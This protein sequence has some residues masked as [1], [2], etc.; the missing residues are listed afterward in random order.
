VSG[1]F[2]RGGRIVWENKKRALILI[3]VIALSV[4]G[5]SLRWPAQ[6]E[7]L[8]P[9]RYVR[10][11]G[12]IEN[13]DV[14]G[15]RRTLLPTVSTGYFSLPMRE[16][17]RVARSYPWVDGVQVAR[18]WPDTLVVRISEQKARVRWGDHS[19]LNQ[20][21]ERF[22]PGGL[23]AFRELPAIV[24]PEGMENY[25][26]GMLNGL[27]DRLKPKG[28]HIASLDMSKRR[29][30]VV[31]LTN[32]TEVHFGRQDP[33]KALNRFLELMPKLGE[34]RI[35][36]VQR[37]DLRYPNGFAVVW[38]PDASNLDHPSGQDGRGEFILS[39]K[40]VT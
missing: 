10:V 25:L 17:E 24:G 33:M 20:R 34:D 13:L 1:V 30:W 36:A 11:E 3:V 5:F 38:K 2:G 19:L 32:G 8:F 28:L 29:A 6:A 31:R 9:I 35:A 23:D 27:N 40:P 22:E 37:V 21:G 26:L 4:V 12:A 39:T 7:P 18:L 14:A 16:I 15:L